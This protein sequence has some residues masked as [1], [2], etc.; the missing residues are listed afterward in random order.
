M[1]S[2]VSENNTNMIVHRGRSKEG[3]EKVVNRMQT[4]ACRHGRG[5][6]RLRMS[7]TS[8]LQNYTLHAVAEVLH[9]NK[10]LC[11]RD[12]RTYAALSACRKVHVCH[13]N[14]LGGAT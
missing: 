6:H 9:I 14:S 13:C 4:S 1:K 11:G 8:K 10:N 2:K 3:E 12:G 7:A 5:F